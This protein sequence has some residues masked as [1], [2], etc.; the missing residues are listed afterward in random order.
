[1]LDSLIKILA[2]TFFYSSCPIMA[3]ILHE[4]HQK[5][6]NYFENLNFY[7]CRNSG[8][9]RARFLP[10][11]FYN[12]NGEVFRN[13][14]LSRILHDRSDSCTTGQIRGNFVKSF[15]VRDGQPGPTQHRSQRSVS[16]RKSS[17]LCPY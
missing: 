10:D 11:H 7:F 13:T 4:K 9:N 17:S 1:M 6:S 8:Q 12:K 5:R 14:N 16:S 2:E 3:R 15:S